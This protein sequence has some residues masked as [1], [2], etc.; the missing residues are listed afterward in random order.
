VDCFRQRL[1]FP[2]LLTYLPR[3]LLFPGPNKI[4]FSHRPPKKTDTYPKQNCFSSSNLR[5]NPIRCLHHDRSPLDPTTVDLVYP[6]SAFLLSRTT[7]NN[8]PTNSL[9]PKPTN[10]KNDQDQA[11]PG[12]RCTD[13]RDELASLSNKIRLW[14]PLSHARPHSRSARTLAELGLLRFALY[15][16]LGFS[17]SPI[18][19]RGKKFI[20]SSLSHKQLRIYTST[21]L[22]F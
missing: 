16:S 14:A 13:E 15:R 11:R 18:P 3:N 5:Y 21:R 10:F 7:N 8:Q 20:F 19:F 12:K 6:A 22:R 1:S 17:E 9:L 4:T 2:Y